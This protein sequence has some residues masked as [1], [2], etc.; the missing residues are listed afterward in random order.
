[1]VGLAQPKSTQIF[2]G[3]WQLKSNLSLDDDW[4]GFWWFLHFMVSSFLLFEKEVIDQKFSQSL[5]VI[6]ARWGK[7]MVSITEGLDLH[8]DLSRLFGWLIGLWSL[9]VNNKFIISDTKGKA[10]LLCCNLMQLCCNLQ[11]VEEFIN[12]LFGK[13]LSWWILPRTTTDWPP[14]ILGLSS[15]FLVMSVCRL[16]YHVA[17][18]TYFAPCQ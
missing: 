8:G 17:V 7:R 16:L 4:R 13:T 3:K 5:G 15:L 6:N 2:R 12:H 11:S 9:P 1:M 10:V 18:Q 14:I